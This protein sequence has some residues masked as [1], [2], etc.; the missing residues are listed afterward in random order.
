MSLQHSYWMMHANVYHISFLLVVRPF[1]VLCCDQH[2]RAMFP[3]KLVFRYRFGA[4]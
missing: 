2:M 3:A 4:M 1:L